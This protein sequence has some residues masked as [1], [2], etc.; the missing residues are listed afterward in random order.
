M[1]LHV[2]LVFSKF[3]GQ[4]LIKIGELGKDWGNKGKVNKDEIRYLTTEWHYINTTVCSGVEID[5]WF[6]FFWFHE[7]YWHIFFFASVFC[8]RFVYWII[9]LYTCP[10]WSTLFFVSP[11]LYWLQLALSPSCQPKDNFHQYAVC[12]HFFAPEVDQG[13]RTRD[14]S[15]GCGVWWYV[16]QFYAGHTQCT[17]LHRFTH[18]YTPDFWFQ[19]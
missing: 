13:N 7:I 12:S 14:G 6:L 19:V 8:S 17:S 2:S 15:L 3:S 18:V 5:P 1:Q 9:C 16:I 10:Q 4:R 11:L